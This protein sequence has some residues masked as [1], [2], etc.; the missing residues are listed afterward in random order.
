[1]RM[2]QRANLVG[3]PTSA[4]ATRV[5][6]EPIAMSKVRLGQNETPLAAAEAEGFLGYSLGC[7]LLVWAV[8]LSWLRLRL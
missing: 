5:I 3:V 2:V 6:Q 1:M 7:R 4:S 8:R